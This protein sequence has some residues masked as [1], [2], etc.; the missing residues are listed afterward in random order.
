[1]PQEFRSEQQGLLEQDSTSK[2][3]L[4]EKE[5]LAE[6]LRFFSAATALEGVFSSSGGSSSAE[7]G[8]SS[9]QK[10]PAGGPD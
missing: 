10:P 3:L 1:V 6:T 2:R 7:G 8:S 9:E 4:R 5:I